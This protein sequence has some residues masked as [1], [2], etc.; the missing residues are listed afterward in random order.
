MPET[1]K[2]T[3]AVLK[4]A[5]DVGFGTLLCAVGFPSALED[6]RR[7]NLHAKRP[8]RKRKMSNYASAVGS[9]Q[10][11][12]NLGSCPSAGLT[13]AQGFVIIRRGVHQEEREGMAKKN[14]RPDFKTLASRARKFAPSP[15][16]LVG[17]TP[18]IALTPVADGRT[19]A[20]EDN[21]E[22]TWRMVEKVYDLI[23]SNVFRPTSS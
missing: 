12:L 6:V 17:P 21:L 9:P 18:T 20:Y 11:V 19:G 3:R 7:A 14:S 16:R 23:T 8:P 10:T 15:R 13:P 4:E 1:M 2:K 5:G 22:R